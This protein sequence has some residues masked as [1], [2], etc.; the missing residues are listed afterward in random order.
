MARSLTSGGDAAT[1]EQARVAALHRVFYRLNSWGMISIRLTSPEGIEY[2]QIWVLRLRGV[3]VFNFFF[4]G[5][6]VWRE[7][8]EGIAGA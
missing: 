2:I 1:C 5:G 6:I 4:A 3:L 7:R 8:K